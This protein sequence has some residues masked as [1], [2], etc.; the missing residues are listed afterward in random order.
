MPSM[1]SK[2]GRDS[3]YA[4]LHNKS[5]ERVEDDIVNLEVA[6]S[7]ARYALSK[8]KFEPFKQSC[9]KVSKILTEISSKAMVEE[10]TV[11]NTQPIDDSD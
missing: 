1:K 8:T 9:L 6:L 5:V 7:I 2:T 11:I 4:T 3:Y 10:D